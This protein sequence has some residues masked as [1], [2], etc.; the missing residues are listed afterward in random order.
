MSRDAEP[1]RAWAL[2]RRNGLVWMT[3]LIL[4][5][6]TLAAAYRPLDGL[7]AIIGLA[8]AAL[9]AALVGFFFMGLKRSDPLIRLAAAAGFFWLIILFALTLSDVLTRV[10]G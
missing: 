1:R 8:I 3:L 6:L 5:G 10:Q 2:W 7:N 4:L 9:K